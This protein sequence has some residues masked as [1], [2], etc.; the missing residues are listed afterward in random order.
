MTSLL[1]QSFRTVA[2]ALV[3]AGG[4]LCQ[5]HTARAQDAPVLRLAHYSAGNGLVGFVLDRTGTPPKLRFDGSKEIFALSATPAT[6]GN[7]S[8]RRDDGWVLLRVD[9]EGGVILFDE[10]KGDGVR[11]FLDQ[12]ALPLDLLPASKVRA[13]DEGAS[14]SRQ[15][16]AATGLNLPIGLEGAKL[17]ESPSRWAAMADAVMVVGAALIDVAGSEP[18]HDALAAKVERVVIRD[19]DRSAI[20][21]DG[22]TLVISVSA[23]R[24]FAGR[25]SS[26]LLRSKLGSL[27]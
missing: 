14:M 27:L 4:L 18:G 7:T 8:L 13:E 9:D 22:K 20:T 15:I 12:E 11:A 23:D 6:R 21:L 25:P 17:D 26:A 5:G 1:P 10:P 3:V 2:G 24:P 19:E 16:N